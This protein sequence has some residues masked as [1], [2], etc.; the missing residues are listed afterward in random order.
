ME[1]N[2]VFDEAVLTLRASDRKTGDNS[3]ETSDF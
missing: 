1:T 3:V 2:N